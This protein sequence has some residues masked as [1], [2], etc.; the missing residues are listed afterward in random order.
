MA[1]SPS[2]VQYATPL[3][4]AAI[5]MA[6]V[7][8]MAWRRSDDSHTTPFVAMAVAASIWSLLD[9]IRVLS[10]DPAALRIFTYAT[11]VGAVVVP[12][13]WLLF[14]ATYARNVDPS[15]RRYLA[16]LAIEPAL[17]LILVAT[18]PWHGLIYRT[19]DPVTLDGII[20]FRTVPGT[21]YWVNLLYSYV[22]VVAGILLLLQVALAG[23]QLYRKQA[24]ALVAGAVVP[25]SANAFFTFLATGPT[26][27]D[28][29]ALAFAATAAL[30]G[31][32]LYRFNLLQLGP[33]ARDVVIRELSDP[34]VVLNGRDRVVDTNPAATAL[35]DGLKP[36]DAVGEYLQAEPAALADT[37]YTA[38]VDDRQ[39]TYVVRW[40]PLYGHHDEHAGSILLFSDVTEVAARE[41]RLDVLNRMLRHN[42]RTDA[43]VILG[44][45]DLASEEHPDNPHLANATERVERL[46]ERSE[47]AREVSETLNATEHEPRPVAVARV[48]TQ[49]VHALRVEYPDADVEVDVADVEVLLPEARLLETA[50]M[51]LAENALEHA[52]SNPAWLRISTRET[53]DHVTIVVE[54]DGPGLPASEK[55]TL[56]SNRETSLTHSS[57]LGLWVVRWI[58]SATGANLDFAERD[59]RGTVV[60]L[61]FERAP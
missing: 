3:L 45:L 11:F 8:R 51:N 56:A 42:V 16:L 54:D 37:E 41:Q 19:M 43:N 24:S 17:T 39:R 40:R 35:F 29:T 10:S 5:L 55:A 12:G 23:D 57:G 25:L 7:A 30:F 15:N 53:G 58:A 44:S 26:I 33:V 13:A 22:L 9:A 47:K 28:Y 20:L 50:L 1:I 38:T 48:V 21:W 2:Q 6:A 60:S 27:V 32:A 36:G 4:V 46:V 14:T 61:Q 34:I 52:T 59:P 18:D 31:T 49:I